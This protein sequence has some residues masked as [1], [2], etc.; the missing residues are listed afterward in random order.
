MKKL[1]C[2]TGAGAALVLACVSIPVLAQGQ[3]VSDPAVKQQVA[4]QD[5]H[6]VDVNTP[7]DAAS[8]TESCRPGSFAAIMSAKLPPN[9]RP[10]SPQLYQGCPLR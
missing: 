7:Q 8:A 10:G 9:A 3:A 2:L 4:V 6:P 5:P 1:S